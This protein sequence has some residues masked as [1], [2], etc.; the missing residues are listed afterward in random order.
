LIDLVD[1]ELPQILKTFVKKVGIVEFVFWNEVATCGQINQAAVRLIWS[2]PAFP[3]KP[4][5]EC[6]LLV[7]CPQH[8]GDVNSASPASSTAP[9]R[10][11]VQTL[12]VY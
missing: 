8:I 2:Q 7:V 5:F 6:F 1:G 4:Y 12:S 3:P 9:L 10:S 11:G